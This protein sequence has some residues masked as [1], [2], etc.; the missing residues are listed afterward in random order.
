MDESGENQDPRENFIARLIRERNA[1]NT[2]TKGEWTTFFNNICDPEGNLIKILME[3]II[4]KN[5]P[6]SE[7]KAA[8]INV[9]NDIR[10]TGNDNLLNITHG[11][12]CLV[13]LGWSEQK[14][15]EKPLKTL[16]EDL[17]RAFKFEYVNGLDKYAK[18]SCDEVMS[19]VV[20][21]LKNAMISHHKKPP[22]QEPVQE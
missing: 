10:E 9:L 8:L 13:S 6:S 15:G 16:A 3:T 19:N 2:P 4:G 7:G 5:V 20:E 22:A 18:N 17:Y 1:S 11:F 21:E 14:L 12:V